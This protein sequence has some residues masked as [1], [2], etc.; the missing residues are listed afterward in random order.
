MFP[1]APLG[2]FHLLFTPRGVYL[3]QTCL[4]VPIVVALTCSAVRAVPSGLLA[5][6]RAFGAGTVAGVGAW[7]SV[8]HGSASSPASS[9]L[10]GRRCP[11]SA[12]SF[13]SAATVYG[14]DQTL[15][16]ATIFAV[17][18]AQFAY[19]MALGI[20]LLGLILIVD[21]GADL[22]AAP[23]RPGGLDA[24]VVVTVPP[25][26][27]GAAA[28][29]HVARG[30]AGQHRRAA[31]R[32]PRA[33]AGG[34]ARGSRAQRRGQEHPARD[35]RQGADAGDRDA[36]SATGGW[37][38]RCSRP[39][40]PAARARAN[41]ELALA[42]WGV[43]R[44]DRRARANRRARSDACR[45]PRRPPGGGDV[46]RRAPPGAPGP[47]D[48]DPAGHPAARRAVRRPRPGQPWRTARRH[49]VGDPQPVPAP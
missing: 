20:I 13:S 18:Q 46:R 38:R 29:D 37:P 17:D 30:T 16:S 1:E 14:S 6:A 32:Q 19:A 22:L 11:R 49:C 12:R 42:W 26:R 40:W 8:S 48:R 27:T 39:T 28:A 2:R 31:R 7:R 15:A 10:S 9:P 47:R 35:H 3:A 25:W 23:R 21:R 36:S 33:G 43:P 45:A 5:Q 34:G 44:R 41:V 24:A 4:A